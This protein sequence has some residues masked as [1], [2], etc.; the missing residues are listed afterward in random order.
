MT[1]DEQ[2]AYYETHPP[3]CIEQFQAVAI[4]APDIPIDGHAG[5]NINTFWLLRCS[6]GNESFFL[7]GYDYYAPNYGMVFISPL[8]AQCTSCNGKTLLLDTDKHGYDP[9]AVGGPVSTYHG[10]T[11]D[12]AAPALCNCNRCRAEKFQLTVR[13][14]FSS[15]NFDY[16]IDELIGREADLFS[17][18]SVIGSCDTC[19]FE[20]VL[21]EFECA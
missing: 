13:F 5:D 1:F 12:G 14:E 17:W 3:K 15:D 11:E 7:H 18:T 10:L 9:V 2:V 21:A 20:D 19:G 4:P 16:P 8:H 6:C